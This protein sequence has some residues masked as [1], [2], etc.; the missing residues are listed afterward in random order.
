MGM[1]KTNNIIISFISILVLII[2][3]AYFQV[4]C[5]ITDYTVKYYAAQGGNIDGAAEQ[6][7]AY[8]EDGSTVTAVPNEGYE[9][10]EWSD[11][12]MTAS[13]TDK[14]IRENL[15]VTAKFEKIIYTVSYI[16]DGN[17]LI[18]GEVRQSIAYGESTSVVTAVPNEG[19]E[20]VEWSDGVT[21]ASRTDKDIRENLSVTAKFE[22][23]IYTVSYITDGNGVIEGEVRQSIAYGESASVVT[24]VPNEGY[25][26]VEW[27]DGVETAERRDAEIRGNLT[28]TALF[29]KKTY[30]VRYET[31]NYVLGTLLREGEIYDTIWIEYEVKHGE[32][33]PIVRALPGQNRDYGPAYGEKY[34]FLYWSDGVTTEERQETNVTSDMLITA[35][36]GFRVEY[37]VNNNIG[38]RIEGNTNQ[39][40]E[41]NGT[42]E[43]VTAVPY[44]GYIFCGWSD[45]SFEKTRQ[46]Q[47]DN[48]I[49]NRGLECIAYFEPIEKTFRYSYG[50]ASGM[51]LTT[52]I[53]LSRNNIN[54]AEFIVPACEGYTFCGWYADND[55]RTRITMENGRYM[56]GYA[57][58]TMESDTLYARWQKKGE[59]TDNHKILLVFVDE[60]QTELYSTVVGQTIKVHSKMAALD[61]ELGKWM[62]DKLY[63]LLNE[64]FGGEIVFEVNS[65]YTTEVIT[66][67]FNS[68]R[69]SSGNTSYGLF[70]TEIN[71]T[72]YLSYFYHNTITVFGLND[73]AQELYMG[74]GTASI[75]NA[76]VCR[77]RIW[78]LAQV[79]GMPFQDYLIKCKS[80][81]VNIEDT[82]VETC[83]H[84]LAHTAE[85]Y[86]NFDYDL[87]TAIG[88]AIREFGNSYIYN[89]IKPYLLGE[90][91]MNGVMCGVP[92]EYWQ[93]KILVRAEYGVHHESGGRIIV[94][95]EEEDPNRPPW[96]NGIGRYLANGA[97][98]TVEAVPNE[99]YRFVR[100]TD[101][102]TTPIRHDKN[103]IAYYRV[104][105]IFEKI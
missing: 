105:A 50:I 35:Y 44:E 30:T 66:E 64:W 71:E 6:K 39:K 76:D 86:F 96:S 26:F 48:R 28:V 10:V 7:I 97:D 98:F 61:Y 103:I 84:E 42:G 102:I 31:D 75:K 88:H 38:G 22:R 37:S 55:Y 99:G 91:D 29:Q 21:T 27:S 43:A 80:G 45:L 81:E 41:M 57:A 72:A 47:L 93:H 65:Y 79:M 54:A 60:I 74:N 1:K 25:E 87:H 36:F 19:Y 62:E 14:D 94:V 70:V 51:P 95:G 11:G 73:Y 2:G 101:G 34:V 3:V 24:A 17:G 9:F 4:G 85:M 83:L 67:G 90:F 89:T 5:K 68:G 77:E 58:F 53:T 13:R 56:Y 104:D 82:I 18:E 16:T 92:M 59:E 49:Y 63:D 33:S 69:T 100:W 52:Q 15:S 23:I 40:V 32:T 78:G 12:V 8:G 46:D 20:F